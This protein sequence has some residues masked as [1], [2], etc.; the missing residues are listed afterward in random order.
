MTNHKQFIQIGNLKSTMKLVSTG[1]PLGSIVGPL[2]FNICVNDIVKASSKFVVI[3]YADDTTLNSTLDIFGNDTEEVQNL[4]ISELKIVFK[5]LDVNKLCLNVSKSKFMLFHMPQKRVPHLLFSI[6][7]M[8]IE[9]VT[10]YNFL[11]LILE[12]NLNWKAH[13]SAISTKISR[14]M[15]LLHKLKFIFPKQVRTYYILITI[16]KSLFIPHI[17]YGLLLWGQVDES[18]DKIQKKAIRTN[19]YSYYIAHS[20]PLLKELNLLKVK[21]LFQLKVLKFLFKLYHNKLPPYFNIYRSDLKKIET[22]YSL[23]PP[24]FTSS[25]CVSCIC[26]SWNGL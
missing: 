20:E 26:G 2:L 6:D 25:S 5:W 12:S 23:R 10:E 3:L 22:P 1:V 4:F 9:Q 21:D 16:Y 7:R 14:V 8:H 11:G 15:W 13:L 24:S 18:L 17:N 19:T